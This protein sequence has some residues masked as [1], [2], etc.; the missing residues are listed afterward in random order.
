MKRTTTNTARVHPLLFDAC[1]CGL[2]GRACL[3]CRRWLN[4]YRTVQRRRATRMATP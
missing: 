2:T 1:R 3:T 4:H